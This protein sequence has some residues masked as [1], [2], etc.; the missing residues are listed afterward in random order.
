MKKLA[1]SLALVLS[2]LLPASA[3]HYS[4]STN[5]PDWA[6]LGTMNMKGEVAFSNN[7]SLQAGAR[8]NPWTY[9]KGDPEKQMEDRKLTV[10]ASVRLWPWTVFT[11]WWFSAGAQYE[12]YNRGGIWDR[13]AEEGDAYGMVVAAGYT[14]MLRENFN[15]EIG[16]G[17]WAGMKEYR[18]YSCP[19]CGRIL[20]SGSKTFFLP[21]EAILSLV[22]VF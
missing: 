7:W 21:N 16:L 6:F 4:V 19:L 14:F 15:I 20:E 5:V 13:K 3:Q 17:G 9:S 10:N 18:I 11:E 2:G 22:Y 12:L 1:I 8:F